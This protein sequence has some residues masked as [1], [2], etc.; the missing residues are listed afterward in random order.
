MLKGFAQEREGQAFCLP[1]MPGVCRRGQCSHDC[2]VGSYSDEMRQCLVKTVNKESI[3]RTTYHPPVQRCMK[4]PSLSGQLCD[5]ATL[6]CTG[7]AERLSAWRH[8]GR[9]QPDSG[10]SLCLMCSPGRF[11]EHRGRQLCDDCSRTVHREDGPFCFLHQLPCWKTSTQ[12]WVLFLHRLHPWLPASPGQPRCDPCSTGKY[13]IT[14][15]ATSCLDCDAEGTSPIAGR[16]SAWTAPQKILWKSE[17]D[18]PVTNAPLKHS[19]MN[20]GEGVQDL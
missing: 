2:I 12:E 8:V 10:S 3:S 1:C 7:P 13:T 16:R 11:Q 9:Y 6:A 17:V 15:G 4:V 19:L 20:L 5:P 18:N 14:S